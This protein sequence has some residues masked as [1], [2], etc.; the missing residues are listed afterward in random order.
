[1]AAKTAITPTRAENYPEWYQQVIKKA[2]MAENSSV[3]GC[4]IIKPWGF[5]IWENI[6]K[7]LDQK[8]KETGHENLYFPLFI[9][10]SYLEREAAHVE[11]FAK[12]CAVVTHHR[13]AATP[14]GKLEPVSPL[15]EPLVVRPTSE[16]IIG[17]AFARWIQSY[18]DLPLRINQW[19]NIVRW[20][21][22]TRLFLRTSEFLWQEGH[23][24]YATSEQA[25]KE[26]LNMLAVYAKFA[27]EYMAMPV[28]QGRKTESEKFP[29]AE[30]TYC[31]EAMMQ[32]KKALQAG[33][34]HFL[35]QNFS[36]VFNIQYLNDQGQQEH[37]W[38]TSWGV[39]TR[40]IGSLIMTHSDDDGLVLPPRLAPVHVVILPVL[41]KEAGAEAL[42]AYC[43][44]L[45]KGLGQ[46][47][48]CGRPIQVKVDDKDGRPGDKAWSWVKKGVPVR[49]EIGPKELESNSV[50]MGRRDK[51]Y[52][53]R[54][55]V[56]KDEFVASITDILDEI[57]HNLLERAKTYLKESSVT[58]SSEKEFYDYFK[59]N[60]G[61]FAYAYCYDDESIEA[62]LK[63]DLSVTM[64]CIPLETQDQRG[65]CIFSGKPNA[66]LILFA[67]AY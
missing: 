63:Q 39:S 40:L 26:T 37:A 66:P 55:S 29:G 61:G 16:T 13:L 60:N 36:K 38:T 33:T 50:F 59:G 14:E 62:K 43:H 58:L 22:R 34:T 2:D 56:A 11:G 48:Y 41:H 15:E 12:E 9:P 31:I 28:I 54:V 23:A 47:N 46:L 8:L 44:D 24:A 21:M 65:T 35:G 53:E 57:Q 42:L 3:H 32:D 27:E 20:E 51:T 1:M 67:K 17:E 30:A 18:R 49:L 52:R 6:Q 4:M 25:E 64:R 5:A 19:A 45:A 7:V 10:L